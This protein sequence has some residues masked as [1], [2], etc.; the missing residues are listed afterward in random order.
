GFGRRALLVLNPA[1]L[2]HSLPLNDSGAA[3]T[4]TWYVT[5]EVPKTG[6]LPKRRHPRQTRSFATEA[7]A[8]RFARL[9]LEQ[10]LAV[11]A[12]TVNPHSPKQHIPP[13]HNKFWQN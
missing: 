12:G 4:P 1:L 10:G 5:F 3:M 13:S 11:F 2:L 9:K 6:I 8:K 7:E